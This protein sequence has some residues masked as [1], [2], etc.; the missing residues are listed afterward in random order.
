MGRAQGARLRVQKIS[1]GYNPP[2]ERRVKTNIEYR[3]RPPARRA[4]ASERMSNYEV[5]SLLIAPCSTF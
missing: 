5:S 1:G 3:T 4:Y 2:H